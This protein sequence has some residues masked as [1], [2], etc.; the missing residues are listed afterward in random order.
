MAGAVKDQ[1]AAELCLTATV[2]LGHTD[3][4]SFM[5]SLCR[6]RV[7]QTLLQDKGVMTFRFR[8]GLRTSPTDRH[9]QFCTP[10]P[11]T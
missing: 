6:N 3:T 1:V 4:R 2:P 8:D 11:M 5:T 9:L 7:R 10:E